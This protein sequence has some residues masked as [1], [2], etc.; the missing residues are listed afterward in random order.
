MEKNT[1]YEL[2]YFDKLLS[3]LRNNEGVIPLCKESQQAVAVCEEIEQEYQAMQL[4][5]KERAFS[6][7]SEME[8]CHYL[9]QHYKQLMQMINLINIRKSNDEP[10]AA[11]VEM[12]VAK[13]KDCLQAIN[14]FFEENFSRF[15]GDD[16]KMPE[17]A[18]KRAMET[19][20]V[21]TSELQEI[22]PKT[23]V[24]EILFKRLEH[25]VQAEN[26]SFERNKRSISYKLD[27]TCRLKEVD[28]SENV[29][30]FSP[31]E[32]AL[33]YMNFN[34]KEFMDALVA[35]IGASVRQFDRKELRIMR[36]LEMYK[37]FKQLHRKPFVILNPKY[38]S[39]DNFINNW[40]EQEIAF[41]KNCYQYEISLDIPLDPP[42]RQAFE[43]RVTNKVLC[44]LT[45]DQL[46]VFIRVI[47]ELRLVEAK[48]LSMV[49]Q[50]I[51]PYLSTNQR[52][53]ISPSS[54][55]SKSY[56]PEIVDKVYLVKVLKKMMEKINNY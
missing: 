55:R 43:K 33:I 38:I 6:L 35:G 44:N 9:Q 26:L 24:G 16:I 1:N 11:P 25:F 7:E 13:L 21:R 4:R 52:H 41:Y 17:N 31:L 5:M 15:I 29:I 40:F 47:D 42:K 49:F 32:K 54:M 46:A 28:Y 19:L 48:S 18:M 36:I 8:I 50:A 39:V 51:V 20:R 2:V 12:I 45:V 53:S 37:A 27:L 3:D 23:L 10:V 22:L 56:N 30:F 34:S 14:V